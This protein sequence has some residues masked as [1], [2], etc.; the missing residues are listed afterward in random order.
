VDEKAYQI[1]NSLVNMLHNA[2]FIVLAEG[3]EREAQVK[4]AKEIGIDRIQ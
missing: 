3:V 4:M 1:V 2:G